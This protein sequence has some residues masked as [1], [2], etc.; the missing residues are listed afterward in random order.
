MH[1]QTTAKGGKP[2]KKVMLD[3]ARTI[4]KQIKQEIDVGTMMLEKESK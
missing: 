4:I 3:G 2:G 1:L